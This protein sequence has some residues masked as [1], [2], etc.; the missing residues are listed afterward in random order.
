MASGSLIRHWS[1]VNLCVGGI[2]HAELH[3]LYVRFVS[4]F[5]AD[6]GVTQREEP[7]RRLFNQGRIRAS[8]NTD[9]ISDDVGPRGPR[10]LAADYLEKYGSDAMRLHLLF[11]G[12][13]QDHVEWNEE[14][15]R[16]CA[17]F[18]QRTHEA[19]MRRVGEGRFV[20][21]N[22]LV[23]KHRL[24]RRVS[25]AIRT[26]RLNKAVSSFMEFVKLLR[27]GDLTLEEVDRQTL[28][29]F[30]ILLTPFA[31]HM[32]HELWEKMGEEGQL[33]DQ[34]WPEHSEEL[35]NPRIRT[36]AGLTPEY[37]QCGLGFQA[38]PTKRARRRK[39]PRNGGST[40]SIF[41]VVKGIDIHIQETFPHHP[42]LII[43][44]PEKQ[45]AQG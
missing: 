8:G 26:F 25:R 22:V 41:T 19:I 13:P 11:M 23:A 43:P 17:R 37:S 10:V 21:R 44:P 40:F 45:K 4:H 14:G 35:L 24:V 29:T 39:Q 34:P 36:I 28:K 20:S 15:L 38:S 12:P 18:L 5:L 27:S 6:I 30:V 1:P 32:A 42:S 7:F 2:E 16:G 33:N 3:L 9:E 31:P